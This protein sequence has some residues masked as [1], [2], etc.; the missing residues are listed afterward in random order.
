ML[1][2]FPVQ[3]SVTSIY[4]RGDKE[5]ETRRLNGLEKVIVSKARQ[6]EAPTNIAKEGFAPEELFVSAVANQA[7]IEFQAL[8]E[9]HALNFSRLEIQCHAS[10]KAALVDATDLQKLELVIVVYDSPEREKIDVLMKNL[11][12]RCWIWNTS[13]GEK[14]FRYQTIN[15]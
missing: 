12:P 13:R 15:V 2:S 8:A 9:K 4:T 14:I 10:T 11:L 5:W 7:A 3:F 6:Y 1:I